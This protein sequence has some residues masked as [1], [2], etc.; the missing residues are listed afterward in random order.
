ML[1]EISR[2]SYSHVREGKVGQKVETWPGR[3]QNRVFVIHG[4]RSVRARLP[5]GTRLV[6]DGKIETRNYADSDPIPAPVWVHSCTDAVV[7]YLTPKRAGEAVSIED[8][9]ARQNQFRLALKIADCAHP[10]LLDYVRARQIA[11][12]VEMPG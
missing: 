2:S 11:T 7:C 3:K 1:P 6:F 9:P 4:S 5:A 8:E 10:V 12:I